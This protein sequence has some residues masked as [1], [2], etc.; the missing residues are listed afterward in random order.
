MTAITG[1]D[2]SERYC[3]AQRQPAP[4]GQEP[5]HYSGP[6]GTCDLCQQPLSAQRYIADCALNPHGQWGTVCQDCIAANRIRFGWGKA[7]LYARGAIGGHWL[8]VAGYPHAKAGN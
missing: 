5:Q 8:L 6:L 3:D 4:P 1:I 7:Q 2:R